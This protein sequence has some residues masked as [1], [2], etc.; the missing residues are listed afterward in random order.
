M[1]GAVRESCGR[2]FFFDS[3]NQTHKNMLLS[4]VEEFERAA[5]NI[6]ESTPAVMLW[7]VG[8]EGELR[9]TILGDTE[10]LMRMYRAIFLGLLPLAGENGWL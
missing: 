8:A 4:S 5:A 7:R 2:L 10:E 9:S 3:I 1:F 6:G